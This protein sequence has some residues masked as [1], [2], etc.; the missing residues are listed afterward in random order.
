MVEGGGWEGIYRMGKWGDEVWRVQ[1]DI[2]MIKRSEREQWGGLT[3][4]P[5][6]D[7][8]RPEFG[9]QGNILL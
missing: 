7:R 5:T 6:C 2:N 8:R 1:G 4:R 9:L 3:T